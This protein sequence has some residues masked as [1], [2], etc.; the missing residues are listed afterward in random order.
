MLL[1]SGYIV[2]VADFGLSRKIENDLYQPSNTFALP[3]AYLAPEVIKDRQFSSKSES[4]AFGIV[5]WE[6]FTLAE[7]LPYVKECGGMDAC[8]ISAFLG[9]NKRL[10]IPDITPISMRWLITQLWSENSGNRPDFEVCQSTIMEELQNANPKLAD[11]AKKMWNPNW[12]PDLS[13]SN[14]RTPYEKLDISINM[15]EA[16]ETNKRTFRRNW[17][18]KFRRMRTVWC[19]LPVALGLLLFSTY[20]GIRSIIR[21]DNQNGFV[22]NREHF[23]VNVWASHSTYLAYSSTNDPLTLK[24][25]VFVDPALAGCKYTKKVSQ[26]PVNYEEECKKLPTKAKVFFDGACYVGSNTQT[27]FSYAIQLCNDIPSA[28]VSRLAWIESEDLMIRLKDI[29]I[30]DRSGKWVGLFD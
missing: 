26:Y 15:N 6:L 16:S 25:E 3:I 4:W 11:H 21:P 27:Q 24:I 20:F 5:L 7:H 30:R 10:P 19:F 1:A 14:Q 12:N 17:I 22:Y 28:G 9:A 23:D 13:L 2:K 18:S 8:A 29:V